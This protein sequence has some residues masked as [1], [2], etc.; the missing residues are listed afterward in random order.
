SNFQQTLVASNSNGGYGYIPTREALINQG[1]YEVN[2][3]KRMGY[4]EDLLKRVEDTVVKNLNQ[5]E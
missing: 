5:L 3:A 1:G 2:S 4:D